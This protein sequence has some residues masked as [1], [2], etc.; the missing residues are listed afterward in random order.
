MKILKKTKILAVILAVTMILGSF[1]VLAS[2]DTDKGSFYARFEGSVTY[3]SDN[4]PYVN[5]IT[6]EGAE[7]YEIIN[8]IITENTL[9]M[10]AEGIKPVEEISV[11]DELVVYFIEP[12]VSTMIF[13]PQREASVFV[14]P[15]RDAAQT[16]FFG[17][18]NNELISD[19]NS[20]KLN[21]SG[22]TTILRANGTDG[23]EVVLEGRDLA[24]VYTIS[25]RSIPAQTT[26][27]LIVILN[28][29]PEMSKELMAEAMESDESDGY[30]DFEAGGPLQL[31]QETIEKL[32]AQLQE[33]LKNAPILVRGEEIVAPETL[34]RDGVVFLPLRAIAEALGYDV[35]WEEE[36]RSV[37]LGAGVRLQIG[38]YEYTVG[39]MAPITLNSTP[40]LVNELTY[41][42]MEFFGEVLGLDAW[43]MIEDGH[44]QIGITDRDWE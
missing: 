14:R 26:P 8:F 27:E 28:P 6:V 40:I 18:F 2:N 15:T 43:Y 38:S 11:G 34:V 30:V 29:T 37:A 32:N 25:T 3:V 36:T 4:D 1:S 39:R 12:F 16:I 42:P 7:D 17:R 21:V 13:P 10:T 31:D 24:V 22:D 20:L 41:V 23:S 33:D 19:D 44:A 5:H 35:F 9:F